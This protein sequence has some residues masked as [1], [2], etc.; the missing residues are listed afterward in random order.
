MNSVDLDKNSEEIPLRVELK[1]HN[2][3]TFRKS[4]SSRQ[5]L[6]VELKDHNV[7][8]RKPTVIKNI[9]N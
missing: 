9:N 3:V 5:L 4:K 8:T 7:T 6:G 1:D 2:N